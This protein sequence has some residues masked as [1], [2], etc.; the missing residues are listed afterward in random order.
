MKLPK[1]MHTLTAKIDR[2]HEEKAE[3]PRPHFGL[4]SCGEECERKLWLNFRWAVIEK[5]SGRILRLFRRGHNEEFT[6]VEDL[7]AAGLTIEHAG[8]DP[9]KRVSFGC[10]VS[11]SLDGII[12]SGVPEAPEKRHILEMKTHSKKSFDDLLKHGVEKSK[13]MHYAQMQVYM[14]GIGIDRA[15]Y[16]SICKDDDRIYTERVKLN[17]DYATKKVERSKRIA[18]S[19]TMP[20]PIST[21]PDWYQCKLCSAYEFCHKTKTTK[22]V[23][24]RTCAHSTPLQSDGFRCERW[25][26]EIPTEAQRKGCPSHVVHPDL[27]PVKLLGGTGKWTAFYEGGYEV[28]E[29][30]ISSREFLEGLENATT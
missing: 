26:S 17:K 28:G 1:P 9:Q 20:P 5:F 22:E 11:G 14:L 3:P 18:M 30:G 25:N 7:K 16:V 10:N 2:H 12:T 6:L 4:S 19:D 21:R 29:D 24:C 15:L 23:N 13:P 27:V 8:A